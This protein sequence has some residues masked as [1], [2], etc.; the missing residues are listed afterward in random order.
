MHL[1]QDGEPAE[2][3]HPNHINADTVGAHQVST[4][5]LYL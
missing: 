5:Y 4:I 2:Y 3:N 1:L